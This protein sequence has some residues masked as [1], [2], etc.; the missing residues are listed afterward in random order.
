MTDTTDYIQ[1]FLNSRSSVVLIECIELIHPDFS[2]THRVVRNVT[3]GVQVEHEDELFYDYIYYPLKVT[4]KGTLEDLD[5]GLQIELGDLGGNLQREVDDISAADGFQIKPICV[6]RGYRSD[7]L[8][9]PIHGPLRLEVNELA[10]NREGAQFDAVAPFQNQT[11]TGR[12]YTLNQFPM[13]RGL[14]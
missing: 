5:Y 9:K 10:F 1:F 2:Q 11:S 6:M 3:N 14:L 12:L 7:D 8:T 4:R 13:L